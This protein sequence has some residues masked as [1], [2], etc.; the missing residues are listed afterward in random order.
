[1]KLDTL[2]KYLSVLKEEY[3]NID[4][5]IRYELNNSIKLELD[6]ISCRDIK[7]V[8]QVNDIPQGVTSLICHL[9]NI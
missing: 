6:S 4:C 1:M 3:G 7:E 9:N 2:I 8:L 5:Y